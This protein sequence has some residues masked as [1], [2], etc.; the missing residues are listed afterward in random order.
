MILIIGA[1]RAK[2][3]AGT[4]TTVIFGT[5]TWNEE[6]DTLTDINGTNGFKLLGENSGDYSGT[7]VSFAGDV[8]SDGIQDLII[9]AYSWNSF[10]FVFFFVILCSYICDLFVCFLKESCDKCQ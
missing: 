2:S 1:P 6:I 7:S 4:T 8:N 9:G 10:H 5:K 3:N